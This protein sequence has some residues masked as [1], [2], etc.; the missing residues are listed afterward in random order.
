MLIA[1]GGRILFIDDRAPER[2]SNPETGPA[3]ESTGK[4]ITANSHYV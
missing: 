3:G 4:A 1:A 2:R